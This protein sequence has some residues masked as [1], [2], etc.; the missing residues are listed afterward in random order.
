MKPEKCPECGRPNIPRN[1]KTCW[2][3]NQDES[4]R[5]NL[6]TAPPLTQNVCPVVDPRHR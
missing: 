3:E 1:P 6:E 4:C 2:R 5:V